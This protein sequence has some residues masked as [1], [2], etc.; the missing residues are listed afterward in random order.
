MSDLDKAAVIRAIQRLAEQNGGVPIGKERFV[1]ETGLPE[2]LFQGRLWI[3][4]SEAVREAGY[5][6]NAFGVARLDDD[7]LVRRLAELTRK[8]GKLPTKAHIRMEGR[9]DPSFPSATTFGARIGTKAQQIAALHAFIERTPEFTDVAAMLPAMA[10]EP[11]LEPAEPDDEHAT[12]P[13]PGYVYLVRSG[14][15]HKIGRSND[16]GRR[17]Y[18]IGLQLPEKLQV[19][20][21]IETDDAVGIE[22]YWHE[23]FR[24]RRRNGEWFVLTKA[25]V[26]AFRRRRLFM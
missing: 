2:Y 21:T 3:N 17:T 11:I 18:E 1:A 13:V 15:Y 19:V 24:D 25:D 20:H 12:Q 16:H 26:A 8:L 23:R 6:P 7:H 22:R 14:K 10:D 9:T 5:E 4:W